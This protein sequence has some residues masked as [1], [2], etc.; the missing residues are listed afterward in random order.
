MN[1]DNDKDPTGKFWVP[2]KT[3]LLKSMFVGSLY[4]YVCFLLSTHVEVSLSVGYC[5]WL[6]CL[7]YILCK[8]PQQCS[9]AFEILTVGASS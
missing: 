2:K 4:V 3:W 9:E 6:A 1:K 5:L 7:S 8:L